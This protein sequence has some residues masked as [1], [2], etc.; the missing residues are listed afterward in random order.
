VG[1]IS[2]PI[3]NTIGFHIIEVLGHEERELAPDI[4]EQRKTQAFEEWLEEQ[5]QSEAVQRY[6]SVDKVPVDTG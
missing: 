1:E 5:Q 4:L 2:E 3:T 6:W